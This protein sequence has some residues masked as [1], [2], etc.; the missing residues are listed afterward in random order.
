MVQ[1]LSATTSNPA[2]RGS[3]LRGRLDARP[4]RFQTRRLQ[5]CDDG[6][7]EFR[8]VVQNHI[9][10][11]FNLR[12]RLAQLLDNPL[13]T[14]MSR[15]VEMENP[16]APVLDDKETVQQLKRQRRHSEEIEGDDDLPVVLEKRQPR[17]TWVAPASHATQ[18]P[19]DG[20]L[21]DNE[22]ELQQLAVDLRGS[23]IQI[24]LR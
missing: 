22:P 5:K 3:I 15:N 14:R 10:V 24:L 8:I 17:F 2:F 6:G 9:T 12:E 18:I 7:I 11:W 19:G 1:N 20:P 16:P 4:L 23:P 21:R 13:R